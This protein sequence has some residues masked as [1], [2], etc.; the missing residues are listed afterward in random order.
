VKQLDGS[1]ALKQSKAKS[2]PPLLYVPHAPLMNGAG[3]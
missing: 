1:A 3:I 2:F